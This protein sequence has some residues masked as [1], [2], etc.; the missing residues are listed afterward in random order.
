MPY[1]AS[2][3]GSIPTFSGIDPRTD[4]QDIVAA[5]D[6]N[7]LYKET[8]AVAAT[9][10]AN[11][12]GRIISGVGT[13]W[14]TGSFNTAS[15]QV[16]VKDRITNVEN[17]TWLTY[18][19]Y[20]SRTAGTSKDSNNVSYGTNVIQ[21]VAGATTTVNLIVKPQTSQTA[22][23]FQALVGSTVVTKIDS[24]GALWTAVFDGG[25]P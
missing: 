3:P 22:D 2:F 23:L 16:T 9:L 7:S 24:T 14:G 5:N 13:N 1:T 25:T 20:L 15:A 4:N 21:P 8:E 12:Q 18:N 10:G 17:G 19:D 11:P 6:V